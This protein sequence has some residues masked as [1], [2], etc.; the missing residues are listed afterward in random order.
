VQS[1]ARALGGRGA[2]AERLEPAHDVVGL[3]EQKDGTH[4]ARNQ[5][6]RLALALLGAH[7]GQVD[8]LHVQPLGRQLG[9]VAAGAIA[10]QHQ[11]IGSPRRA[12]TPAA[13][14][15]EHL[16]REVQ[17]APRRRAAAAVVEPADGVCSNE[18]F[19]ASTRLQKNSLVAH[20]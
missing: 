20:S 8:A 6:E 1:E 7:G 15:A 4:V 11:C 14:P 3:V 10:Q 19:K 17:R 12:A 18:P 16:A 13:Q 9:A 2:L 5:S